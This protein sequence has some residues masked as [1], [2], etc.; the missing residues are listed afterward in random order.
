MPNPLGNIPAPLDGFLLPRFRLQPPHLCCSSARTRLLPCST[1][2]PSPQL[3]AGFGYFNAYDLLHKARDLD[4]VFFTGD[5][6][7]EYAD[8]T[9]PALS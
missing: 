5:Y 7:Y 8:G 6:I 1:L 9:F 2:L 3:P 4:A